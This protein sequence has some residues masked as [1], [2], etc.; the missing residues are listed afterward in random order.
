MSA[1]KKASI[2]LDV[3]EFATNIQF[4]N[5]CVNSLLTA[6]M[7]MAQ[8]AGAEEIIALVSIAKDYAEKIDQLAIDLEDTAIRSRKD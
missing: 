7:L 2:D 5:T 3:D 4:N 6:I 1:K 8:E